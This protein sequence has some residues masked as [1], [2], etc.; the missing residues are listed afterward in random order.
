[1]FEAL[2]IVK[3][4]TLTYDQT[5]LALAKLSENT[6]DSIVY[7]DAYYAAKK[8]GALCDLRKGCSGRCS[9]IGQKSSQT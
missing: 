7:S 6:D 9:C 3:D 2:N 1:M 4:T 8:A 5:L